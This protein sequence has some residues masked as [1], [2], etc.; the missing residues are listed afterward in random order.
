M[1]VNASE[2]GLDAIPAPLRRRIF[3]DK[4]EVFGRFSPHADGM[5]FGG[6]NFIKRVVRTPADAL[7][8]RRVRLRIRTASSSQ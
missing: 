8:I 6:R 1:R 7:K 3:A 2:L 5:P 4:E